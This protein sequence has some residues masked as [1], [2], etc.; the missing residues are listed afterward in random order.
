MTTYVTLPQ[1]DETTAA[2]R[3]HTAYQPRVGIILG[4]GLNDLANSVQNSDI[5]PYGDLPNWPRSTVR[6]GRIVSGIARQGFGLAGGGGGGAHLLLAGMAAVA[7]ALRR[8]HVNG[9]RN[10]ATAAA[11]WTRRSGALIADSMAVP[12][13]S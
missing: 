10:A 2:V 6:A 4:S 11:Y 1:I 7:V 3:T 12:A 13:R 9:G 5:M 8:R